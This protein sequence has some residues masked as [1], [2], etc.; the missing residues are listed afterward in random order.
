MLERV[1]EYGSTGKYRIQKRKI[2]S[3]YIYTENKK[4]VKCEK[5][6]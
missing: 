2:A 3:L 1:M 4:K 5:T 6:M